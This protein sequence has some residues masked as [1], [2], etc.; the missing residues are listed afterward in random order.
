[1][2]RITASWTPG[3]K[4]LTA[5]ILC[6]FIMTPAVP[7][8]AAGYQPLRVEPSRFIFEGKPGEQLTGSIVVTNRGTDVTTPKAILRD[9]TLDF[10]NRLVVV[11]G[12][13]LDSTLSGWIKFNPRQFTVGPRETQIV[14]FTIK[15]PGDATP[16]ERRGMITFEQTVPYT[17]QLAGAT[18][19][20]QVT[21]TIYVAVLPIERTCELVKSEIRF[22]D[23]PS[24]TTIAIDL[25]GTGNGHFRGTGVYEIFKDGEQDRFIRGAFEPL[26]VMPQVTTRFFGA[27]KGRLEPGKY[28]VVVTITS[29]EHQV[30]PLVVT[31]EHV[32]Q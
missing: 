21:S 7:A 4:L 9:W 18:A 5:I 27:W 20:V 23:K 8:L 2:K 16:G 12:G 29:E 22:D 25:S 28:K 19:R 31:F 1:M 3:A 11:E 10:D 15:I 26:V 13:T 14:R 30:P 32:E 17:D 24:L 6:T